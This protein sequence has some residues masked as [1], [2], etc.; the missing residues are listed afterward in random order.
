VPTAVVA[1][2]AAASEVSFRQYKSSLIKI[3]IFSLHERRRLF[4]SRIRTDRGVG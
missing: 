4:A 2:L 1:A 3:K